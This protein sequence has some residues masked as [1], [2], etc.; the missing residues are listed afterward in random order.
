[1]GNDSVEEILAEA[2]A[3]NISK[4]KLPVG[5]YYIFEENK[6]IVWRT[7][8][9]FLE[10]IMKD[11]FDIKPG[12]FFVI[13]NEIYSVNDIKFHGVSDQLYIHFKYEGGI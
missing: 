10:N 7:T 8:M 2:L 13:N 5:F 11:F 1:M 4:Y 9:L 12:K 3:G 6:D